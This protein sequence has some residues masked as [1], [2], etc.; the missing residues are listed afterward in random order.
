MTDGDELAD[1]LLQVP[2]APQRE[3]RRKHHPAGWEPGV[4]WDPTTGRGELTVQLED[5]PDPALWAEPLGLDP[6]RCEV[7]PGSVQIRAWD[8]NMGDGDVRRMPTPRH[9]RRRTAAA[10]RPT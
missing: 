8:A 7:V 6:T 4:A 9:H 10:T 2:A 5:D 1:K 3:L